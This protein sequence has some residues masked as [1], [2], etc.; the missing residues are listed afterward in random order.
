M[1]KLVLFFALFIGAFGFVKDS[2]AIL[3]YDNFDSY[4]PTTSIAEQGNWASG[5]AEV[6]STYYFSAPNSLHLYGPYKEDAILGNSSSTYIETTFMVMSSGQHT[7]YLIVGHDRYSDV[8]PW[9]DDQNY[10]KYICSGNTDAPYFDGKCSFTLDDSNYSDRY[11]TGTWQYVRWRKY[12]ASSSQS[13]VIEDINTATFDYLSA[14]LETASKPFGCRTKFITTGIADKFWV[15]N[16]SVQIGNTCA[17]NYNEWECLD[18]GCLWDEDSTPHCK[19]N[20][21]YAGPFNWANLSEDDS[22]ENITITPDNPIDCIVNPSYSGTATGK[23][24]INETSIASTSI[25]CGT[26]YMQGAEK[27]NNYL[28]WH[29]ATTSV[30]VKSGQTIS[31]SFPYSFPATTSLGNP[32]SWEIIYGLTCYYTSFP[33]ISVYKRYSCDGTYLGVSSET[34]FQIAKCEIDTDQDPDCSSTSLS[35]LDKQVCNIGNLVR[36]ISNPSCKKKVEL[37][38]NLDLVRGR[39]PYNY[40]NSFGKFIAQFFDSTSTY[41]SSTS[42]TNTGGVLYSIQTITVGLTNSFSIIQDLRT[43]LTIFIVVLVAFYLIK[44]LK[45]MF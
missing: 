3:Y 43:F 18:N 10:L 20:Y 13:I 30:S 7:N 34:L 35:F 28:E 26:L 12:Y 39:V 22:S 29:E 27:V 2:K 11:S 16:V 25:S 4:T 8:S 32:E 45:H 9:C 37:Q 42:A 6:D 19:Q 38:Q 17:D 5:T 24:S 23:I 41:T 44:R 40:I 14:P 15:E 21:S 31:Y 36:G 1:K 33:S